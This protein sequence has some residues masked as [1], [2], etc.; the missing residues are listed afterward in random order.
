LEQATQNNSFKGYISFGT[1]WEF[2]ENMEF[3]PLNFYSATKH[4]NDIFFNYF[5]QKKIFVPFLLKFLTLMVRMT[6]GIKY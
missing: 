1:K 6:K 2:N 5:S 3:N 4:A